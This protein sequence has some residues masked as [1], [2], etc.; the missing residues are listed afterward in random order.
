[1]N[2]VPEAEIRREASKRGIHVLGVSAAGNPELARE[3]EERYR[4]W[5]DEGR[6]GSMEYL[7]RHA[8][9]KFRPE[10]LLPG[11]KSIVVFGLNY[12]QQ[13]D[14][15]TGTLLGNRSGVGRVARYAWG[16]DYHKTLK[17]ILKEV[18]RT[19][20]SGSEAPWRVFTDSGPLHERYFA[21]AAGVGF[22]GRNTLTIN[23]DLGSWF[24]IG[25]LLTT[26]DPPEGAGFPAD[27]LRQVGKTVQG[28]CPS[29]CLRCIDVCPT[30]ALRGPHD[31]DASKCI[32]YLTIEH[33]G[34]I[35]EE[36]RPLMGDWIF[37]CDL[38]Q[39]VCPLNLRSQECK[40]EDFVVH[41]AG[42]EISLSELVA[43]RSTEDFVA[44]F[45][46]SPV[47]RAGLENMQ[48]NACIVAGNSDNGGILGEIERLY[49]ET[50]SAVV[51][52]HADWAMKRILARKRNVGQAE[53]DSGG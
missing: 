12:Y 53:P 23:H 17:R 31:I 41:R 27:P 13:A 7:P 38:C 9:F 28:R 37:G 19:A 35:A 32:S 44:R 49:R 33:R 51:R 29:S 42:S 50:T 16:R 52:E 10:A 8:G 3:M 14:W 25:V 2:A 11:C 40:A 39:E 36:L 26:L 48:R 45:A 4:R 30:G 21:E 34:T 20:L 24:F 46:G 5:L 47:M 43:M 18:G 1:M 15:S 6:A 22:T